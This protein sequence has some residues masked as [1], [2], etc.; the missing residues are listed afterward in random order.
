MQFDPPLV[1]GRFVR[2]Y[3]RFFVDVELENGAQVVAHCPNTGALLGCLEVGA[4]V[5]LMA[6][7][8]PKRTLPFGWKLIRV[9]SSWVG[10]DS[11]MA[12]SLVEEALTAGLLP[13]LT[14][15]PRSY[16]E[17]IY[18]REQGSRIDILLSRGGELAAVQG[19][20]HDQSVEGSKFA[21]RSAPSGAQARKRRSL[22]QGDERVYVEVKSTTL[23][24][25][26]TAMFPDAVTERGQKHLRELM[27]VV[28]QG[29]RAAMVYC[30][31]RNDCT[32]FE[33]ADAIDPAYGVLLRQAVSRG[34]EA[35]AIQATP[36]PHG[37]CVERTLEVRL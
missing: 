1:A 30:V 29:Q 2:R 5:M 18:G 12:V 28:E 37:V 10:V 14:G 22:P 31:Q 17:V 9:G 15:Y 36:S 16:R 6:A 13:N 27:H 4:P 21:R 8:S 19:R 7:Q 26:G 32:H 11:A 25:S 33:P 3:K 20:L 35:Y 24:V 23:A 34:V